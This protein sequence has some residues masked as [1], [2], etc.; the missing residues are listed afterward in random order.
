MALLVVRGPYAREA[1]ELIARLHER[2]LTLTLNSEKLLYVAVQG[3][4]E[5]PP[6]FRSGQPP[7]DKDLKALLEYIVDD[8][9]E[10]RHVKMMKAKKEPVRFTDLFVGLADS[11]LAKV[12]EIVDK[13][14]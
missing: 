9:A 13:G 2:G 14:F 5:E 11:G 4:H 12:G 8:A 1:D 10:E 6:K 7:E 3:W